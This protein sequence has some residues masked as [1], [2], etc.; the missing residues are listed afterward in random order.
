MVM[1]CRLDLDSKRDKLGVTKCVFA[2]AGFLRPM[3]RSF[4][5]A[6]RQSARPLKRLWVRRSNAAIF[7]E[8]YRKRFWGDNPDPR[9]PYYSGTGSYDTSVTDYVGLVKSII[10][11]H[12]IKAVT[13]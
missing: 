2:T 10:K 11:K 8:I 13:E 7:D 4:Y 3:F 12:N 6:V 1:A 5:H 9:N